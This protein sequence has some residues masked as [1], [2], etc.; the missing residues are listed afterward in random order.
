MTPKKPKKKFF[1]EIFNSNQSLKKT[2]NPLTG[3]VGETIKGFHKTV[4][5]KSKEPRRHIPNLTSKN[6]GMAYSPQPNGM[7]K[8]NMIYFKK[9]RNRLKEALNTEDDQV[10]IKK[11]GGRE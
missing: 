2:G 11:E 4:K 6:N 7:R 1:K 8:N 9:N 5:N 3:V 10:L